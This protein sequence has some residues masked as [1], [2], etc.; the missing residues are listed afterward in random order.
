MTSPFRS[1]NAAPA[2]GAA[3]TRGGGRW[4]L[5]AGAMIATYMAAWTFLALAVGAPAGRL[6][7]A[8]RVPPAPAAAMRLARA[9]G[10]PAR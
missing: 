10:D 9:G 8:A 5:A 2:W 4:A 6:T 3:T 7:G 1:P